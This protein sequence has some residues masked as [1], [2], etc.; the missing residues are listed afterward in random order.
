MKENGSDHRSVRAQQEDEQGTR[1][2]FALGELA[3]TPGALKALEDAGKPPHELIAR[4]VTGDWGDLDDE[5]KAE[6]ELSVQHGY[7]VF[8]SYNL[9]TGARV[10]VITEWDRTVTTLLLPEEY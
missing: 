4:H 8:S 1:P 2:R 9:P 7:R 6:N 10:W 5:D 3:G